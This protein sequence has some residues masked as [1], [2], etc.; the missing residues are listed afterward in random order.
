M[1]PRK[2]SASATVT[3]T[4]RALDDLRQIERFSISEWGRKAAK[5]Y[6][7]EIA[8]GLDR[9]HVHPEILR[10]EPDFAPGLYF[11]RVK[12]HF[13]VCDFQ[14]EAITILTI[15]HTQMDLPARLQ[16]LEPHLAAEVQFLQAKL[17]KSPDRG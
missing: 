17:H 1:S 3:L 14:G 9:L 12:K 7:D 5:K 6:L 13:L 10:L 11:Y 4:Q 2:K 15:I 16:E 8:S